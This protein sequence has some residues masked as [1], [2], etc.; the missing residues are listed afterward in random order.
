MPE[1]ANDDDSYSSST[2]SGKSRDSSDSSSTSDDD[3]AFLRKQRKHDRERLL[4]LTGCRARYSKILTREDKDALKDVES[5][6]DT[7]AHEGSLGAGA[8]GTG[9]TTDGTLALLERQK[10]SDLCF[11]AQKQGRKRSFEND[12]IHIFGPVEARKLFHEQ[13][14][15]HHVVILSFLC[16]P[17]D[18]G[19]D[20]STKRGGGHSSTAVHQRFLEVFVS[21][22]GWSF[23]SAIA[24]SVTQK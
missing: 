20:K 24:L 9:E 2:T 14:G 15:E 5:F 12:T 1:E 18:K 22:V 17:V 10:V 21:C 4:N 16:D 13:E 23:S 8:A 19:E 11:A 6:F 7:T 3:S